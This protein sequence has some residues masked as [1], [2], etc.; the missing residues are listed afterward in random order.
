MKLL[1]YWLLV[2]GLLGEQVMMLLSY[3]VIKLL[4]QKVT[5]MLLVPVMQNRRLRIPTAVR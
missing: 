2:I 5:T 3:K 4:V 1:G